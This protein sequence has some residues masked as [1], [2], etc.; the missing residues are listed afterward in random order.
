MHAICSWMKVGL[1]LESQ[2][3]GWGRESV[4][5]SHTITRSFL[6]NQS[7]AL[8]TWKGSG[9]TSAPRSGNWSKSSNWSPSGVPLAGDSVVIGGHST[10]TLTLNVAATPNLN[11]LTISD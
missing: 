1:T 8:K 6:G 3:V 9:S 11:S 4:N 7:M 2:A 10:Y 5:N